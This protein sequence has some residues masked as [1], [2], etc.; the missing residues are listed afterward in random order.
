MN[1]LR[2]VLPTLKHWKLSAKFIK[3]E[4]WLQSVS[5]LDHI[6]SSK[7]IR[8]DFQKIEAVKQCPRPTSPI[9]ITS[10]LGL[11]G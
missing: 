5:F 11:E 4:F 8:M 1:H 9:D 7:G 3:C 6:V 2:V 10:F